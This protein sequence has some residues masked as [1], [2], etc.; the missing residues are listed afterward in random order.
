MELSG[1][2]KALHSLHFKKISVKNEAS[3]RQEVVFNVNVILGKMRECD[4][5]KAFVFKVV[6]EKVLQGI[7]SQHYEVYTI[8][9]S[10][11]KM[12]EVVDAVEEGTC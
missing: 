7:T 10:L 6:T 11:E 5:E 12:V 3:T 4:S 2:N 1:L 9:K 8:L